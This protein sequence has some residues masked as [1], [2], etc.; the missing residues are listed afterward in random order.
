M[1]AAI[2]HDAIAKLKTT[3]AVL[4]L[5][6]ACEFESVPQKKRDFKIMTSVQKNFLNF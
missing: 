3:F 4:V 1:I 6:Q 5:H 2:F